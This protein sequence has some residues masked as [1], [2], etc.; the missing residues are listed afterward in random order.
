MVPLVG[1][2][3]FQVLLSPDWQRK[4][5][6]CRLHCRQ[7]QHMTLMQLLMKHSWQQQGQPNAGGQSPQVGD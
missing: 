6:S 1:K 5:S 7:Q 4:G 3:S 2:L